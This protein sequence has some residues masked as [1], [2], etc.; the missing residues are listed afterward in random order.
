MKL[1]AI[2]LALML[3]LV[4]TSS[5]GAFETYTVV[6]IKSPETLTVRAEPS[7][8][9]KV[10]DWKELGRLP[11]GSTDV[12]GT[13]RSKMIGNQRW[14]EVSAGQTRGWVSLKFLDSAMQADLS[15]ETFDCS[16]T[17]PFWA[18][19]LGPT[20]SE[21]SDPEFKT[22][23]TTVG[24]QA[25]TARLLPLLYRLADRDEK[26]YQA[27]IARQEWCSDGMS[28]YDYGFQVLLTTEDTLQQGCCV[29]RR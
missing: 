17:E 23:L 10:S 28:D 26:K 25:A 18:A 22:R 29:I 3:S 21:Y 11:A 2:P 15:R 16:G 24:V 27:T 1:V 12:R 9:E 14:L 8:G 20:E 5:G 4:C 13:G 6:G 19:T 7:D